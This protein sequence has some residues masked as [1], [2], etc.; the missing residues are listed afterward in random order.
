MPGAAPSARLLRAYGPPVVRLAGLVAA[1]P[2]AVEAATRTVPTDEVT[3]VAT[4]IAVVAGTLWLGLTG[5]F[6]FASAGRRDWPALL[7]FLLALLVRELLTL[8]TVEEIEIKFAVG[9]AVK[10]SVVYALLQLFLVPVVEDTHRLTMQMNAVLGALATVPLYVFVRQRVGSRSAAILC[11]L[12][13]AVHPLVAR[14]APTDAPYSLMLVCW[15]AALA[16]LSAPTIPPRAMIGAALLLGIAATTRM[17]GSLLLLASLLLLDVRRLWA[18]VRADPLVALFAGLLVASL[19]ALQMY[20]MLGLFLRDGRP[21]TDAS[22]VL[23]GMVS[24]AIRLD[25]YGF[26]PLAWLIWLGAILGLRGKFRLGLAAFA[27]SLI[28]IA[29]V[30]PSNWIT[31]SHR[32]VPTAALQALVAGMGAYGLATLLRRLGASARLAVV[33]GVLVAIGALATNRDALVERHPFTDE[34]DIIRAHLAPGG[35]PRTDCALMVQS[36]PDGDSL[37]LHDP[38]QVVP[39]VRLLD[40]S[41][42]DCPAELQRGGCL[43]YYRPTAAYAHVGPLPVACGEPPAADDCLNPA[44]RAFEEQMTLDPVETRTAVMANKFD[45]LGVSIPAEVS[46]GLFRVRPRSG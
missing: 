14:F 42:D 7:P 40:C 15:F 26:R 8:H 2:I 25:W 38:G 23:D 13:L 16:L 21:L 10:H 34:Y 30:T 44:A 39:Q 33:P 9:P 18:A 45:F 28:V 27:A 20:A 32:L 24:E 4:G 6:G 31:A 5:G 35:R 43:F 37:D 29:P 41:R 36:R 17:E 3:L 19:G 12:F 11:A 1:A 46:I 22:F